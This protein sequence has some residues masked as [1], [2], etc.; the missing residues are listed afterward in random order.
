[1]LAPMMTLMAGRSPRTPELTRPTTMT[2]IAVLD[3]RTPV[4]TVPAIT[5][6]IGVPAIFASRARI[7]FT[8]RF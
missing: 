4:M 5:P 2:V 8:A 6:L 3:W 7:R 1:M